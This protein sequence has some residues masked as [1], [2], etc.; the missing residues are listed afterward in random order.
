[1]Q[2]SRAYRID[3]TF[4]AG[5]EDST[6]CLPPLNRRRIGLETGGWVAVSRATIPSNPLL[7]PSF[8]APHSWK[9]SKIHR[10]SNFFILRKEREGGRERKGSSTYHH[11]DDPR[12]YAWGG[13]TILRSILLLPENHLSLVLPSPCDRFADPSHVHT[14]SLDRR[15]IGL[16]VFTHRTRSWTTRRTKKKGEGREGGRKRQRDD[17][18]DSITLIYICICICKYIH[19]YIYRR[20]G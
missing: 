19:I 11:P 14:T 20:G 7:P 18:T 4:L 16:T 2:I 13:S 9:K 10:S 1:M 15:K 6:S 3:N 12:A 5:Q 17:P 8:L